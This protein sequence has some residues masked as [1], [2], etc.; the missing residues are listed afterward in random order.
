M[1]QTEPNIEKKFQLSAVE[2]QKLLPHRFPFL[3]VDR[4]VD[5]VD[6]E[7]LIA[8]K[9][10]SMNEPYFQGHFPDQPIMPGVIIIEA[11]AQASILFAKLS[12]GG[13]GADTLMVFAGAEEVRFRRAVLPGDVLTLKIS[14]GRHRLGCWKVGAV[15]S[16]GDEVA[17]EAI[18]MAAGVSGGKRVLKK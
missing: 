18:L 11:L 1:N 14:G 3:F 15:A 2:V 5:F 17:T 7:Y 13:A 10:V 6:N 16:V 9:A 4:V 8:E 12:S